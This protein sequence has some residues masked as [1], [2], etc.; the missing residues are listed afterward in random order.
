MVQK[1]QAKSEDT[2]H[3]STHERGIYFMQAL[4]DEVQFDGGITIVYKRKK[5]NAGSAGERRADARQSQK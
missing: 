4:M 2:A 1:F 3:L 5:S